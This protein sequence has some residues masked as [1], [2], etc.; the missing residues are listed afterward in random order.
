MFILS[1]GLGGKL[2]AALWAVA[3]LAVAWLERRPSTLHLGIATLLVVYGTINLFVAKPASA[4]ALAL[5]ICLGFGIASK[6]KYRFVGFNL[7][8][9]DLTYLLYDSFT[10][11]FVHYGRILVPIVAAFLAVALVFALLV[12][13]VPA[14]PL[15]FSTRAGIFIGA[16]LLYLATWKLSG[17]RRRF[18]VHLMTQDR[19]HLSVF[20]AS[21]FGAGP[22]N[23]PE[24]IDVADVAL[25]LVEEVKPSPMS[26]GATLPDIVMILHESTF[27]PAFHGLFLD[28]KTRAFFSPEGS[29]SGVLNVDIYGG[30]TWQT[31]FAIYTGLSSL[32]FGSDSRF[33][34]HRLAGRI[35]HSLP[36]YLSSLGY[37][38]AL[39]SSDVERF[40]N[41][42]RF[43]RSIGFD[44]INYPKDMFSEAEF[45]RWK[46]DR[47]DELH[48]AE[49]LRRLETDRP[50]GRP[51]F[52]SVM[53][54]MNHGTHA[55]RL[56]A[57][58]R[59]ADIRQA[60][61]TETGNA[62]Y[63]EYRVRLEESRRAY[64]AL[65]QRL[66][67][68]GRP[69]IVLRFGDHHPSFTAKLLR[70]PI[71]D[72]QLYRTFF[73]IEAI[74]TAFPNGFEPPAELDT[75][76]LAPVLLQAAGLPLDPV[77]AT[78]VQLVDECAS[79]Y[80]LS[81]S[82]RK[83]RFHRTLVEHGYVDLRAG[84]VQRIEPDDKAAGGDGHRTG[85]SE[86]LRV[87]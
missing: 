12:A 40:D 77:Y 11:L 2:L 52:V 69:T 65:R 38:T 45:L 48:Y 16:V 37:S 86:P 14:D 18:R 50:D 36:G 78:R 53:T 62:S 32:S 54:L 70:L 79:G 3:L 23:V 30:S 22:R 5:V 75:A 34:F 24:F 39:L 21:F 35:R 55:K 83:K 74:N 42:Y 10:L 73:S 68:S 6:V 1:A 61:V 26:N 29:A 41:G 46:Q 60:A 13:S 56:F 81:Q 20:F 57:D 15:P 66:V 25:P 4:L 63:G 31:E 17:G 43:Y 72:R 49:A 33:V 87:K 7:V 27:N 8:A 84:P 51:A 59:H 76:L 19:A 80:H 82:E 85:G 44:R 67:E 64:D 9:G 47:H 28:D 71:H 58:D